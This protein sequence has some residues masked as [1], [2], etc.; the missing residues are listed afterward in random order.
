MSCGYVPE[1]FQKIE[2]ANPPLIATD[3]ND[4][5]PAEKSVL[6]KNDPRRIAGK[7]SHISDGDTF[8]IKKD[9][10]QNVT[11]RIHAIDAPELSQT[12]GTQSRESLRA[13]I[14]NQTVEIRKHKDDQ[15]RRVVGDVFL[16]GKDIGLEQIKL[17]AAW[18]YRKFQKELSPNDRKLFGDA[19]VHAKDSQ[20]GLWRD[21]RPTPPWDYRKANGT[22]D[23]K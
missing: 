5:T 19:E 3:A 16:N 2:N 1:N 11:V 6:D 18:Y 23:R 10:G 13:L 8:I 12:Y 20:L 17:G 14:A 15:Y 21:A 22:R 9:D 7:V 4:K